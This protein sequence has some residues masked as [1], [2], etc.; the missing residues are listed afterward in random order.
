MLAANTIHA[1]ARIISPQQ[2]RR[3]SS[4][5]ET[6]LAK[7]AANGDVQAFSTLVERYQR[8]IFNMCF[9][10]LRNQ[11]AE[12]LAQE[13]FIK[14]FMNRA[15]FNP[16]RPLLPWLMTIARNLCIDRLR[17]KTPDLL[18]P[19]SPVTAVD[20]SPSVEDEL[21]VKQDLSQLA[22]AL[23]KLPEGQREAI[24]LCYVDGLSYQETAEVLDV[25]IGTVMTWLHRGRAK[26]RELVNKNP[27]GMK[28]GRGERQ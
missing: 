26:L 24:S 21:S 18:P 22:R 13:T 12:D 9:R 20:N 15:K 17:K 2:T 3:V 10:Y 11:D 1:G 5:E 19:D 8:P 28:G 4:S 6:E 16:D 25:P 23:E 14:A 7:A 27:A